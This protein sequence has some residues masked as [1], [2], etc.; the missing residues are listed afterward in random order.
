M[1]LISR[2]S[3][4]TYRIPRPTKN[5]VLRKNLKMPQ[6]STVKSHS[7]G[8]DL[9]DEK[10]NNYKGKGLDI[11]RTIN[12]ASFSKSKKRGSIENSSQ[13]LPVH[14]KS[15]T[16]SSQ[17]V[18]YQK[19]PVVE[20]SQHKIL[21]KNSRE[22]SSSTEV[23]E[24]KVSITFLPT[25]YK[26][27]E[28]DDLCR[29]FGKILNIRTMIFDYEGTDYVKA[30]VT[31]NNTGSAERFI[32]RYDGVKINR[33]LREP[34][35]VNYSSTNKNDIPKLKKFDSTPSQSYSKHTYDKHGRRTMQTE[36]KP[37][38]EENSYEAELRKLK[39]RTTYE[40]QEPIKYDKHGRPENRHRNVSKTSKNSNKSS[41]GGRM[42]CN[43]GEYV[44]YPDDKENKVLNDK[45]MD[46]ENLSI[47]AG[48]D[49]TDF[50]F[51]SVSDNENATPIVIPEPVVK[52]RK[53]KKKKGRNK[54]KIQS[55]SSE[56]ESSILQSD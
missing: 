18:S 14:L 34:L 25:F 15:V 23:N 26:K 1:G 41:G 29:P 39:S 12:F 9:E 2:V 45:D 13:D 17:P 48:S 8:W 31:F 30:T 37:H 27:P 49:G 19:I 46:D 32:R 55:S 56:S 3:S 33:S 38:K 10:E 7:F 54:K 51:K 36:S 42:T 28:I 53:H 6:K 40:P 47:N 16:L 35:S 52:R 24:I 43:L 44:Y 11:T 4:R 20:N 5:N 21:T 50:Q 22:N